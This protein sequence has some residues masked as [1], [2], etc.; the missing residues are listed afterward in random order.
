MTAELAVVVYVAL[1]GFGAPAVVARWRWLER[2]P[3]L[4]VALWLAMAWSMVAVIVLAGVT[5]ALA[6]EAV[7]DFVAELLR[8]CTQVLHEHNVHVPLSAIGG[9]V[10][11]LLVVSWLAFQIGR[12]LLR[13][14]SLRN[15]H[16]TAVAI[17]G[18][19]DDELDATVVDHP[20]VTSYCIPGRR[21]RI[22]VSSGAIEALGPGE[23]AAMIAHERAHLDGRHHLLIGAARI[24]RAAFP[25]LPAARRAP[26]AVAFFVERLA[27]ERA[28]RR[29]DRGDVASALLTAVRAKVPGGTLGIGG[30]TVSRR[31]L[32]LLEPVT[33]VSW[34]AKLAG[35]ATLA[36]FAAVPLALVAASAIEVVL[37]H[38]PLPFG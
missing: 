31:L 7:R 13:D 2:T 23:L 32:G 33:P 25:F 12:D 30:E 11:A 34:K 29:H 14:H 18:R 19:R 5:V 24:V 10:S 17:L 15:R 20:D 9:G 4:G 21:G 16:S 26:G 22:V 1:I 28:S 35:L 6:S 37:E 38:C 3:R 36:L 8:I 27:D